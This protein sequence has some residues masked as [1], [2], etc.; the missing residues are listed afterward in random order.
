MGRP[1]LTPGAIR[2]SRNRRFPSTRSPDH[3]CERDR[4]GE[5]ASRGRPGTEPRVRPAPGRPPGCVHQRLGGPSGHDSRARRHTPGVPFRC[6]QP[7][8]EVADR[9]SPTGLR[10]GSHAPVGAHRV[11][12][13]GSGRLRGQR[14][15]GGDSGSVAPS[16]LRSGTPTTRPG[17]ALYTI[18]PKECKPHRHG[19]AS[20]TS[21]IGHDPVVWSV[22]VT[23]PV[24]RDPGR[25]RGPGEWGPRQ[26]PGRPSTPTRYAGEWPSTSVGFRPQGRIVFGP[27]RTP[28][29]PGPS[30][31]DPHSP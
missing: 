28:W 25:R 5:R 11:P 29:N 10:S 30:N 22:A 16:G 1:G 12:C 4:R 3:Q 26:A 23:P 8:N 20:L 18:D 31:T 9:S 7:A 15:G 13:H 21:R 19:H 2:R 6:P 14:F 24:N 27:W 17:H